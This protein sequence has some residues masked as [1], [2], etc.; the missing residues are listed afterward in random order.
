[1]DNKQKLAVYEAQVK[2]VRA[3]ETSIRHIR[4]SINAA[5]RNNQAPVADTFT[6]LYAVT[7]CAWAEANFSKV[8]HTPY[9]FDPGE[10][11]QINV[12]KANGIASAWKKAV[13]LAVKKLDARRGSFMPN[14]R[15][16]L[17]Q[18]I[19]D[20]VFEPSMLRNKLAHGQWVEALNRDND[21]INSDLT[22]LISG[23]D[24]VKVDGWR[25]CHKCLSDMVETLIESPKRTFVRD[26]WR[27]VAALDE[28]M[29]QVSLRSLFDHITILK[30][31]DVRTNAYEKRHGK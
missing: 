22:L 25:A 7:F 30:N 17:E 8:V 6:K 21:K 16:K 11:Q 19:N 1:M 31:K 5:L 9:G 3:I 29:R 24:I 26:W 10:I 2:N 4:R 13:E 18:A 15:Q 23:L 12:A 14:T 20:H 27:A 28:E